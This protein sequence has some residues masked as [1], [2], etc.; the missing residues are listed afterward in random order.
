VL[1]SGRDTYTVVCGRRDGPPDEPPLL[2]TELLEVVRLKVHEARGKRKYR[3]YM[4]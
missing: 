3:R 4:P 1:Q 2:S